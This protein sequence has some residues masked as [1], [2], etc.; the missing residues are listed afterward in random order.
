MNDRLRRLR[1][2]LP[3]AVSGRPAAAAAATGGGSAR[4][5]PASRSDPRPARPIATC[6]SCRGVVRCSARLTRTSGRVTASARS[7]SRPA[8]WICACLRRPSALSSAANASASSE[9]EDAAAGRCARRASSEAE[10]DEGG[11]ALR[12]ERVDHASA[13]T[14][15]HA[16]C[17]TTG[18]RWKP[19][20][21]P[22]SSARPRVLA[23]DP[24][25]DREHDRGR[26]ERRRL[27]PRGEEP[28][29]H[30]PGARERV[31][32]EEDPARSRRSGT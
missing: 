27:A 19:R 6:S 16:A 4:D 24:D 15:R 14:A 22:P 18:R 7:R 25:D 11:D 26:D 29:D 23:A 5:E 8:G 20:A 10:V 17:A 1:A 13:Q 9:N 31:G 2:R 30:L 3:W 12:A 21:D 28:L 32:A